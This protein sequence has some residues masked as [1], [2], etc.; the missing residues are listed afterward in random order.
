MVVIYCFVTN[1]PKTYLRQQM[2]AHSFCRSVWKS[3]AR[4]FWLT[5]SCSFRQLGP[6]PHQKTQLGE[7]LFQVHTYWFGN[8]SCFLTGCRRSLSLVLSSPYRTT[9]LDALMSPKHD[10]WLPLKQM[11]RKRYNTQGGSHGHLQPNP[12]NDIASNF[13]YAIGHT[14]RPTLAQHSS[15]HNGTYNMVWWLE[16]ML[17]EWWQQRR[18]SDRERGHPVYLR[19]QKIFLKGCCENWDLGEEKQSAV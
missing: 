17:I 10:S 13:P 14:H 8:G 3:L 4:W 12:R 5:A 11:I 6:E 2:L 15:T 18:G 1:Y 19:C 9:P 7:D 16:V